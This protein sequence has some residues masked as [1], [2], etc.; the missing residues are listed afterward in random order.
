MWTYDQT[1]VIYQEIPQITIRKVE[2]ENVE[3]YSYL[4]RIMKLNGENQK[5]DDENIRVD[6]IRETE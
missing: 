5:A 4:H 1:K 2:I 6:D 3:S